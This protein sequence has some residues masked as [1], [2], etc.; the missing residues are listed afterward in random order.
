M[1]SIDSCGKVG[2]PPICALTRTSFRLSR[3]TCRRNSPCLGFFLA[4]NNSRLKLIK[5][6]IQTANTQTKAELAKQL[7]EVFPADKIPELSQKQGYQLLKLQLDAKSEEFKSR[8]NAEITNKSLF[9]NWL[10]FRLANVKN[11]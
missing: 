8:M 10:I 2:S 11:S 9:H 7:L 3:F 4:Y 6:I 1:R 5:G